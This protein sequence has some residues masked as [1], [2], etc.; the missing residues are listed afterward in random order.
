[1]SKFWDKVENCEH[2]KSTDYDG[3]IVSCGVG[4]DFCRPSEYRCADCGVY[5]LSCN[6]GFEAFDGWTYHRR[7]KQLKEKYGW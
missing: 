3:G 1:M 2:E 6:C 5:V 7:M 4:T